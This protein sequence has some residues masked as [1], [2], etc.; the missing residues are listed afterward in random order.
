MTQ[1][2]QCQE[3]IDCLADMF[4]S[5]SDAAYPLAVM[6][7]VITA[8][9]SSVPD[10]DARAEFVA[11]VIRYLAHNCR[12]NNMSVLRALLTQAGAILDVAGHA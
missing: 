5:G 4:P 2:E 11:L 7:R 10:E 6:T 3:V 12:V 9:I 1:D 8:T